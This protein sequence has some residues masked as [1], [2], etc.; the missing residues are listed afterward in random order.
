MQKNIPRIVDGLLRL[1]LPAPGR[2]IG[3]IGHGVKAVAT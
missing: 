1:M 2:H 3:T